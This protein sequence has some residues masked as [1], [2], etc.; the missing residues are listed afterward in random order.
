MKKHGTLKKVIV[1]L[2]IILLLLLL[3]GYMAFRI[4]FGGTKTQHQDYQQGKTMTMEQAA[5]EEKAG[6]T[7]VSTVYY[8][9]DISSDG[10]LKIY[11]A[12]GVDLKGKVG[13]KLSFGEKGDTYYLDP[14]LI[15][16]LVQKVNG[17]F[18]ECNTAYGGSRT[19]TA[20]HLQVAKDH[21]FADVA[22]IDIMDANGTMKIPVKGG[23]HLKTD[24]VGKDLANYDSILVLS[25][26]KG[27]TMGGFGGAIKNISIGIA[28]KEGKS[29][30]HSGGKR[31][32][33]ILGDQ[34][35][36]LES[37]AEAASAVSDYEGDN[38]VYISVMNNLSVDCDCDSSPAKPT[39]K[40]IGIFASTD[41]LALDQACVDQVYDAPDGADLINRIESRNGLLTL[42]H[43]AE[44]GLGNRAYRLVSID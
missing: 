21:G 28:S 25:H 11:D 30:I 27:H 10:L 14:Q 43:A 31:T 22:K 39:M 6:D 19:S 32:K 38:I 42:K 41:P 26:F 24:E 8:T 36:F 34:N 18:I 5:K 1:T 16:P 15:K 9:D 35:D 37:M 7:S 3:A 29:L 33:G 23:S 4:Y 13:V 17:T 2:C 20:E 12:L 44:M 40:D